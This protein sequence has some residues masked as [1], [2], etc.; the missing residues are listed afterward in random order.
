DQFL[1]ERQIPPAQSF[2]QETGK[3]WDEIVKARQALLDGQP[4]IK[5][6]YFAVADPL[7]WFGL[8]TSEPVE[9]PDAVVL[10]TQRAVFQLWK[11][12]LP[13]AK[14]GQVTVANAGEL[15]REAQLFTDQI[16]EAESLF[17]DEWSSNFLAW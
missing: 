14:A 3:A 11:H 4:A 16:F 5:K 10:R 8:P 17:P 1:A 12:D 6:A 13:W 2:Q 15:L 9:G 7:G